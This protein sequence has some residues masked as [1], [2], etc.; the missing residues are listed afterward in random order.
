MSILY[1]T[2]MKDDRLKD[3]VAIITGGSSGIGAASA[4]R[5]ADSG[6][7]IVVADLKSSG[8]EKQIQ[9]KHGKDSALFVKVDVTQE[10][11]VENMVQEAAKWGGRVDIICNYAGTHLMAMATPLPI[12][13]IPSC[14]HQC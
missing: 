11:S 1:T 10:S 9:D 14:E 3:R 4:I 2:S 12:P 7:R 6:A 13:I 8:I 5:F